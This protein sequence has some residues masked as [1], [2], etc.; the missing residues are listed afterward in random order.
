MTAI[1]YPYPQTKRLQLNMP[2][3]LTL[4][5]GLAFAAPLLRPVAPP[6][7]PL[8]AVLAQPEVTAW[9]EDGVRHFALGD[10]RFAALVMPLSTSTM[11]VTGEEIN[12]SFAQSEDNLGVYTPHD[13]A[14]VGNFTATDGTKSY[15]RAYVQFPLP[16]LPHNVGDIVSA[17]FYAQPNGSVA[18]SGMIEDPMFSDPSFRPILGDSLNVLPATVHPV[19]VGSWVSNIEN[20]TPRNDFPAMGDPLTPLNP[21]VD[22]LFKLNPAETDGSLGWVTGW[23]ATTS[24]RNWLMGITSN[25]GFAI[26]TGYAEDFYA[27]DDSSF[28]DEPWPPTFVCFPPQTDYQYNTWE[29]GEPQGSPIFSQ[30]EGGFVLLI[31]YTIPMLSGGLSTTMPTAG[32]F[33]NSGH[34]YDVPTNADW[35]M[36]TVRG[37]GV[38]RPKITPNLHRFVEQVGVWDVL[39]TSQV[40]DQYPEFFV[41]NSDDNFLFQVPPTVEADN[42]KSYRLEYLTPTALTPMPNPGFGNSFSLDPDNTLATARTLDLSADTTVELILTTHEPFV[43]AEIFPPNTTYA[44]RHEGRKLSRDGFTQ[45]IEFVVTE[46]TA[47]EWLLAISTP[48]LSFDALDEL[49]VTVCPNDADI[50]RYPL[51]GECLEIH[52]P[53]GTNTQTMQSVEIFSPGGFDGTC[54]KTCTTL[55]NLPTGEPVMPMVGH[56]AKGSGLWVALKGGTVTLN[57]MTNSIVTSADTRLVLVDFNT[58]PP[59][60]LP[61]LRGEF[62][63]NPANGQITPIS[64][65]GNT[66]LLVNSPM[67]VSDDNDG[68]GDKNGWEYQIELTHGR[69]SANGTM[70]RE[71]QPTIGA[72]TTTFTFDAQWSMEAA[73]GETVKGDGELVNASPNVVPFGTLSVRPNDDQALIGL[74]LPAVQSVHGQAVPE[75]AYIAMPDFIVEQPA[76]LGGARKAVNVAI[77]APGAS[78][79]HS[80]ETKLAC[81]TSCFYLRGADDSPDFAMPDIVINGN[82][83]TAMM[84]G[85]H[86]Y[87]PDFK[88]SFSFEAFDATVRTEQ[89]PCTGARDPL[90]PTA[91]PEESGDPTLVISGEGFITLPGVGEGGETSGAPKIA[92]SFEICETSLREVSITF[93]SET[94]AIPLGN[95]QMYMSE[96]SGLVSIAPGATTIILTTNLRATAPTE[97][98]STVF[99]RGHILISSQGFVNLRANGLVKVT[100]FISYDFYGNVGIGWSPLDLSFE[101]TGCLPGG[102]EPGLLKKPD[103]QP[104]GDPIG[105]GD[106]CTGNELLYGMIRAAL[107]RGC[108]FNNR[109]PHLA[110]DERIHFVGEY[111]ASMTFTK[112]LILQTPL[113][114]L[115]PRDVP[116]NSINLALGEFCSNGACTQYEKGLLG[117]RGVFG[118]EVGIYANLPNNIQE[119]LPNIHFFIGNVDYCLIDE[120]G[121]G[122]QC[123]APVRSVRS[124]GRNQPPTVQHT[125]PM[126]V[127][128]TSAMFGIGHNHGGIGRPPTMTLFEPAPGNRVIVIGS[129]E[130][131]IEITVE[132]SMMMYAIDDPLPGDWVIQINNADSA[133]YDILYAANS[134][135]T[136][137]LTANSDGFDDT[138]ADICWTSNLPNNH[139][140]RLNL[141]FEQGDPAFNP[142]RGAI[143]EHMAFQPNGCYEWDMAAQGMLGVGS[144]GFLRVYGVLENSVGAVIN[145]TCGG[146]SYTPKTEAPCSTQFHPD[147]ALV[148][149]RIDAPSFLDYYDLI[150]PPVSTLL[151]A[152]ADDDAVRVRFMQPEP[153]ASYTGADLAGFIVTCKQGAFVRTKGIR[154]N[155]DLATDLWESVTVHG[156]NAGEEATC[157]VQAVDASDNISTV[158]NAVAV[159]LDGDPLPPV[160]VPGTG[161]VNPTNGGDVIAT[162]PTPPDS[163]PANYLLFYEVSP[164]SGRSTSDV[165][166]EANEGASPIYIGDVE[167]FTLTGLTAGSQLTIRYKLVDADYNVSA[168]SAEISV[169]VGSGIPLQVGLREVRVSADLR[170]VWITLLL[171]S[172]QIFWLRLR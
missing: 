139:N 99:G 63:I 93:S 44:A 66:H 59:T 39:N 117:A 65:D 137:N 133:D 130:P 112:G 57:R 100:D 161:S 107:W 105:D 8:A 24:V 67:H 149:Q 158:S 60:T 94:S 131:D 154:P 42:A 87:A 14:C 29:D 41:T 18:P 79:Q 151:A 50:I 75:F 90:D 92:I 5:I 55:E 17:E 169:E 164:P 28:D 103:F 142:A 1:T 53:D 46:E 26:K 98:G 172:V 97:A 165:R 22:S 68:E 37:E 146:A 85:R 167:N 34:K 102:D 168:F 108:G 95:S 70:E 157:A 20:D 15:R 104:A 21:E 83:R 124:D 81:G 51:D 73:A 160:P 156:L 122:E 126:G 45:E 91:E 119:L 111:V 25:D 118:F 4:L 2:F 96:I 84:N 77:Y 12:G 33:T 114:D 40:G 127:G 62:S 113:F 136:F 116:V 144:V 89:R 132:G 6:T 54:A 78:S 58:S 166:Y 32:D 147:L 49:T 64:A 76:D 23:D 120:I 82:A 148:G 135:P 153:T 145:E 47:G 106:A 109:Y 159:P 162:P 171:L 35:Q 80:D 11:G 140:M 7:S 71:V 36:V 115:P 31:E 155:Y 110:C 27:Y 38:N 128:A 30:G 61:V 123:S 52:E 129:N 72:A 19:K 88:G 150:A 16:T 48:S 170:W 9:R 43:K 152:V 3:L 163:F 56:A 13:Q 74:L 143:I 134:T 69:L 121:P 101:V 138:T 86:L 10:G 125:V 141:Y